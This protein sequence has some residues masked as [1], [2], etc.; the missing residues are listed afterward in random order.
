MTK[1]RLT[2]L[3]KAT[4]SIEGRPCTLCFGDPEAVI[5]DERVTDPDRPGHVRLTGRRWLLA[6]DAHQVDEHLRCRRC[7]TPAHTVLLVLD[8]EPNG[9]PKDGDLL[10]SPSAILQP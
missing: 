5:V 3:E 6:C 10:I 8:G 4:R 2:R 7:G 1:A 9:P